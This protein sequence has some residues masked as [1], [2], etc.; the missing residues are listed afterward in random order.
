MFFFFFFLWGGGGG[1][2]DRPEIVHIFVTLSCVHMLKTMPHPVNQLNP[3]QR[4]NGVFYPRHCAGHSD[5]FSQPLFSCSYKKGNNPFSSDFCGD[6]LSSHSSIFYDRLSFCSVRF[7]SSEKKIKNKK[8]LF[9]L[10]SSPSQLCESFYFFIILQ[11]RLLCFLIM[12]DSF[13]L[14]EFSSNM[15][16][17]FFDMS[18]FSPKTSFSLR[19]EYVF[20][21]FF[22]FFFFLKMYFSLPQLFVFL[23]DVL[24]QCCRV[25]HQGQ[26]CKK[27]DLCLNLYSCAIK[28]YLFSVSVSLSR[29][30]V[31]C[32]LHAESASGT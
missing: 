7:T 5:D 26:I 1:G 18:E 13:M 19:Q 12:Y 9:F 32:V 23:F 22:L 21:F 28:Y 17:R 16:D 25:C 20:F 14:S 31:K 8:N 27:A 10:P 4:Y 3:P 29:S 11:N 24:S 15:Y 30:L 6:P 2:F